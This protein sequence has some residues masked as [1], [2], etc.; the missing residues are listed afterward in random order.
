MIPKTLQPARAIVIPED[1]RDPIVTVMINRQDGGL[2][3][4][5]AIVDGMV[6]AVP[7]RNRSDITAFINEEGKLQNLGRNVRATRLMRHSLH[8]GDYIAGHL[9][10]TGE[11][12]D[13]GLV[14]LPAEVTVAVIETLAAVEL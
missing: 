5:Q 10:L 11:A 2:H 14:D 12:S 7:M 4:L 13:G 1:G 8:V 3:H 6:E 9:V